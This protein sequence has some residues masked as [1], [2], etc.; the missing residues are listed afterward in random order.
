ARWLS[1]LKRRRRRRRLALGW[2]LAGMLAWDS[3][4]FP[5]SGMLERHS[6]WH[7]GWHLT[8]PCLSRSF[9]QRATLILCQ[10]RHA[11]PPLFSLSR[12]I[13]GDFIV[14]RMAPALL[15]F[16][17]PT[18]DDLS[19]V[20]PLIDIAR[21]FSQDAIVV[22]QQPVSQPQLIEQVP[23]GTLLS[24]CHVGIRRALAPAV[25]PPPR[26]PHYCASNAARSARRASRF[27]WSRYCTRQPAV[28]HFLR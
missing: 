19:H 14:R 3:S 8:P 27:C 9:T 24:E 18:H 4:D 1:T 5:I 12:W 10:H 11:P 17:E 21:D 20:G 26:G 15:H 23:I 25:D 16:G 28:H 22:R 13:R 6:G 2:H 7:F